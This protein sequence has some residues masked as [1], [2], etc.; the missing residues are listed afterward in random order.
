MAK[1]PKEV[2][3]ALAN[4]QNLKTLATVSPAGVPNIVV[5]GTLGALDEETIVFADLRIKKTKENLLKN[6]SFA[7]NVV[8]ADLRSYQIKGKYKDYQASGPLADQF[9]EMVYK[10]LPIQI[11]GVVLGQVE[12]VYSACLQ[13]AG[14][15]LA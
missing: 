15:K 14:K 11:N 2:I 9:N 12:E 1:M 10:M 5:I 8:G 6:G 13:D 7:V 3:D 4:P